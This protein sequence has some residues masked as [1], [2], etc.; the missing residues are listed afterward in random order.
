MADH[1]EVAPQLAVHLPGER[2]VREPPREGRPGDASDDL[3]EEDGE[4]VM[5]VPGAV[6][7]DLRFQG[8]TNGNS[9]DSTDSGHVGVREALSACVRNKW[10]TAE[11]AGGQLRIKLG[12]RAKKVREG[13]EDTKA[14]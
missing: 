14:A 2:R 11:Q 8:R 10:L 6:G 13:K 3:E 5:V 12:E 7:G 1:V 9:L 4:P